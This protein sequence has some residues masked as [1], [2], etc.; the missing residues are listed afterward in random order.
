MWINCEYRIIN[1]LHI[2]PI[3]K[4]THI[5]KSN[6]ARLTFS[7]K[8][9][10]SFPGFFCT[11]VNNIPKKHKKGLKCKGASLPEKEVLCRGPLWGK[12]A[13]S[14]GRS[15][16]ALE[17][18][19]DSFLFFGFFPPQFYFFCY[20]HFFFVALIPLKRQLIF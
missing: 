4:K 12:G 3:K 13:P 10:F 1:S 8:N 5:N 6:K 11:P 20:W 7:S 18:K 2:I 17:P 9:F 19:K 15:S 14:L 16:F